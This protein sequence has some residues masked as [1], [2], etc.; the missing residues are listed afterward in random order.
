MVK[1]LGSLLWIM[2]AVFVVDMIVDRMFKMDF[3]QRLILLVGMIAVAAA[4]AFWK[5]LK[6][7]STLPG[8]DALVY[9][10]EKG[11]RSLGESL[12]SS[13]E[14]SRAENLE[15]IGVSEQLASATINKGLD[16][17]KELDFSNII[18]KSGYTRNLGI[19]GAGIAALAMLGIGITQSDF[20]STWFNRNVLLGDAQWP[21]GTYLEIV[22]AQDG[23]ISLPRGVNHRQLVNVTE[24]STNRDVSLNLELESPDGSRTIYSMKPTGKLDGR[25]HS[26]LFNNLSSAFRFRA[27]GGDDVTE[28][29]K[30]SLV[31]PPAIV[32]LE[33]TAH[34]PEYTGAAP[35]G[36]K[37][38]GPHPLLVGTWLDIRANSNKPLASATL[39][40]GKSVYQMA[41]S[42][43]GN[44]FTA[45]P[46]KTEELVAGPYEFELL[47]EGNLGN[48]RKS[49]FT[50]TIKEDQ[51]PR[52]RA[53]LLGISGLV[54]T[55]AILP[56]EFQV[57][58]DFG[59]T[60][61][62][63]SASWKPE[64]NDEK[65]DPEETGQ[66]MLIDSLESHKDQSWT[67]AESAAAFD[68]LP[69]KL[70]PGTS[71]KLAVIS[72]D[73][74]P[75]QAGVGKS[76]EFLL[77]VVTD[78]K[79]RGDLLRREDEQ[80]KAFEQAYAMQLSLSSELEALSISRPQPGSDTDAFHKAREMQLLELVRNQKGIGTAIDQIAGRFEEFLVEIT[81][82]RL[83]EIEKELAPDKPRINERYDTKII[84]PI[85]QID[86]D[87]VTEATRYLDNCRRVEKQDAP[88]QEAVTST[89]AVQE[90]ILARM[91]EV[92][93]AMN[94]SRSF[95][96]LLNSLLEIKWL[97]E[98]INKKL[99]E[100]MNAKDIFED[101]DPDDIFENE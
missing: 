45:T 62:M 65:P 38:D 64:E 31:E 27:T 29:V 41:L 79:L 12:I 70:T 5:L 48:A 34:L 63:F 66:T 22:G 67:A 50:V 77:R 74:Q 21:Q 15:S 14:L 24:A 10:I 99:D 47:D 58:D 81:N 35:L 16:D 37:G 95:Q 46:G 84:Q 61:I 6:P 8:N 53:E 11:N 55:R 98:Q 39:K 42:E 51:V 7:I 33:I 18:D 43:D 26:F 72:H 59:L 80:R 83:D 36:L 17:V 2:L 28:W 93:K 76:Q 73:N 89:L 23:N 97:E 30:V 88:L 100:K 40:S 90:Q 19:L 68:L 32:D 52:I 57:V 69:L 96:D 92:L 54:S 3:S 4:V 49:K 20:L 75:E 44:S 82:N 71:L 94:A 13:I 101:A 78:E 87:L 25:Q 60:D 9:E 56:T 91:N 86:T 1:G 85:R